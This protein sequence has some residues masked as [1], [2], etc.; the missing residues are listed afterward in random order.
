MR[1]PEWRDPD[2]PDGVV[3]FPPEPRPP[4]ASGRVVAVALAL[5]LL[6]AAVAWVLGR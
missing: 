4:G 3:R 2:L 5:L 6:A 1:D